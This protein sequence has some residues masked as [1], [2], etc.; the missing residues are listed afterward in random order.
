MKMFFLL[1]IITILFFAS[2]YAQNVGIGTNT[3]A[4]KLHIKGTADTTQLI[5]DANST[6]SNTKPLIKLRKSDG[7]DLMWIHSDNPT[8]TFVG[9]TAGR[10]NNAS[11]G[12]ILNTFIGS[13]AGYSNT[14]G[15]YN[16]AIG[17]AALY[18][19]TTGNSNTANGYQAL[20][21]NSTGNSNT[22]NGY[23]A[24]Y[25]NTGDENTASG[26]FALISNT[27]GFGNTANGN[28][29]LSSNNTGFE[30]VATGHN[31]LLTN[32]S[33]YA[34]TAIGA[35]ALQN[36]VGGTFNIAIGYDAGNLG[37]NLNNTVGI[38]NNGYLPGSSN[39]VIIGNAGTT[40]IGGAVGWTNQSDARIKNTIV[41]DV[42]G[43]DF[44]LRLRPVTYHISDKA[45]TAITGNKETPDFPGKY[46][47][48]KVK[49]TGFLAQEVEQAAK[50]AGYD[51]SGVYIPKKSTELYGLRYAEFVVPLVKAVQEQQTIIEQQ[52]IDIETLKSQVAQLTQTVN[53]LIK[54]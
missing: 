12:G 9:L 7:T 24:L 32:F 38:G 21:T 36:N 46:D 5:I 50:D 13:N 52:K 40:F 30:N 31:A 10:V 25:A 17:N 2:S 41:E 28:S 53:T 37:P 29:A 42:K 23:D 35:Y 48:E 51:F 45:I 11:D 39:T 47:G 54:K 34:N 14:A 8:N 19:N 6:Q 20:A 4:S 15:G 26:S 44:I 18:S 1:S 22:A 33:G 49:Y 27:N 16:T 43:L 3:P